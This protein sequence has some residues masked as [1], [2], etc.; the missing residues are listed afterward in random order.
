M[1]RMA[2]SRHEDKTG[3]TLHEKNPTAMRSIDRTPRSA[4]DIRLWLG[5]EISSRTIIGC[6]SMPV[7]FVLLRVSL[8]R[9][10]EI[11]AAMEVSWIGD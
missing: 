2:T 10:D 1:L 3:I 7:F 5:R 11:P 8:R 4:F 9:R 6:V